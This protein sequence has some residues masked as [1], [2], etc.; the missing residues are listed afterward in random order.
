MRIAAP[1][2]H[3]DAEGA[4]ALAVEL[5]ESAEALRAL[6]A[7]W[8]A[9]FRACDRPSL[10]A[11]HGWVVA[12]WEAF[13]GRPEGT[14]LAA[15]PFVVLLRDVKGSLV[16]AFP[17]YEERPRGALRVRRLRPMGFLG[18]EHAD[19]MTE[20]PTDL[21]LPGREA[22]ALRALVDALRPHLRRGRWDM[23]VL[24]RLEGGPV[25]LLHAA[26]DGLRP[27]CLVLKDRA[28]GPYVADLPPSWAEY[29]KALTKSMRDNLGYYPRLLARDG[30]EATVRI[31]RD[32]GELDRAVT[33]L[34]DLHRAR[35]AQGRGVEHHDHLQGPAQVAFLRGLLAC[36]AP[37]GRA[38]VAELVVGGETIASGAFVQDA[39]GLMIYYSGYREA[40]YRYSPIFVI[41][42]HVFR[43][44]MGRGVARL[45]FLRVAGLWKARWGAT[46]CVPMDRAFLLPWRPMALLRMGLYLAGVTLRKDV[47]GRLPVILERASDRLKKLREKP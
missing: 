23:A 18:R 20:E 17:F 28:T 7:E 44:A 22:R 21:V 47:V 32:P 12:W 30:H 36:L 14:G 27:R 26:A 39:D 34:V 9:L 16:A 45:D 24:R 5:V 46:E 31:V 29:R 35:A 13:A 6:A 43:D 38:F 2:G 40:W 25:P 19:S 42:A 41:D 1:G 8:D 37:E 11:L 10:C 4:D 33:T 15:A 3:D